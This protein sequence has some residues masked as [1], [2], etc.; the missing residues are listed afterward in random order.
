MKG[1]KN[2]KYLNDNIEYIKNHADAILPH[3]LTSAYKKG[4][5]CPNCNNGSGKN[6]TGIE[7][8][9]NNPQV[10]SCIKCK[11]SWNILSLVQDVERIDFKQSVKKCADI[12]GM[13]LNSV[14]HSTKNSNKTLTTNNKAN[15]VKKPPKDLTE[16]YKLWHKALLENES[17]MATIKQWHLDSTEFIEKYFGFR[18]AKIKNGDKWLDAPC[19]TIRHSIHYATCRVLPPL[20]KVQRFASLPNASVA[21][22]NSECLN[23]T[24]PVIVLEGA[25]DA[26]S[27]MKVGFNNVVAVGGAGNYK[28][29][30]QALDETES[31]PPFVILFDPDKT[32]R[33]RAIDLVQALTAK[34]I[35]CIDETLPLIEDNEKTDANDWLKYDPHQLKEIIAQKILMAQEKFKDWTPPTDTV[36]APAQMNDEIDEFDRQSAIQEAETKK[37]IEVLQSVENFSKY[38]VFSE[39]VL[40]AAALCYVYAISDFE[41][42]R[43]KCERFGI[44]VG[45]LD[46]KIKTYS[47]PIQ[48]EKDRREK[49]R[50]N[51]IKENEYKQKEKERERRRLENVRKVQELSNDDNADRDKL[52]ELVQ[53][54]LERDHKGKILQNTRNFE[55]IIYNDPYI[56]NAV[57]FNAFNNRMTP[58]KNLPWQDKSTE[59]LVWTDSDDEG[60][61][62]YIDRV[63]NLRSEKVFKGAVDEYAHKHSYHPVRDFF[64]N[65]PEWDG[66]E[67]AETIFVDALDVEDSE[68]ARKV[69]L[70]WLLGGVAR[71]FHPGCKFDYTLI[72][73]GKQGIGKSTI[74]GRLAVNREWFNDSL[75]SF[76]GKDALE[77]LQGSWI[78]ELG[79]MQ[80][81]KKSENEKI[82]SFISRQM[83]EYRKA[84]GHRKETYPRQCIF[85]ATTNGE[86]FLKDRTGGRRFLILVSKAKAYT[87]KQRMVKFT[88]EYILQIWAE[89]F[90]KYNELFKDGF[91]DS[92]LDIPAHLKN[93]A[94]EYQDRYTE[95]GALAGMVTEYLDKEFP[96]NWESLPKLKRRMW[97][98]GEEN[99]IDC[100]TLEKRDIIS[101]HEIAYEML[102]IDNPGKDKATINEISE[103]IA[104]LTGWH[105]KEQTQTR[106]NE[107][108]RQK[109]V[110]ERDS[111]PF[112]D[113]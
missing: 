108:G 33:D 2:M 4:Y 5:I 91:D 25:K 98:R 58:L 29:L 30:I 85:S 47:K 6:G 67:R 79:E 110:F 93:V 34:K 50:W 16:D 38:N 65:L 78:I 87:I 32:G 86:E 56:K 37:A 59:N 102:N 12:L 64:N 27:L 112:A 10:I 94:K 7:I 109:V 42:F 20:D 81:T 57:G 92:L 107:Y 23:T 72:T 74:L 84:Y 62:N 11:K 75:D 36:E 66:T 113:D 19:I 31:R 80:A 63:Y 52:I 43:E 71:I 1:V 97:L 21:L 60:M 106:I 48:K 49:Q 13:N 53:Q 69:T 95:G 45:L 89:V 96:T 90:H 40:H 24:E 28:T 3:I 73:K 18:I 35:F 17:A 101:A 46:S 105:R 9:K 103:I 88:P 104:N 39:E 83:D 77:Q 99:I 111:S 76:E 41:D 15:K 100:T 55:L 22:F 14:F 54:S 51:K 61:Q 70:H 26:L 82:K 68:Y 8:L 44:R